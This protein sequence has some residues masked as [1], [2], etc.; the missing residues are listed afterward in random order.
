MSLLPANEPSPSQTISSLP[1]ADQLSATAQLQQ[2]LFE[3]PGVV[4][5]MAGYQLM[6][7]T[8]EGEL[9]L[10][11][12][13]HLAALIARMQELLGQPVSVV[14]V[15]GYRLSISKGP[16]RYLVTPFGN[17]PLFLPTT[18]ELE[19]EEDGYLGKRV[20]HTSPPTSLVDAGDVI[21][22]LSRPVAADEE[23]IE[24]G[25]DDIYEG[26]DDGPPA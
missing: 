2:L 14:P 5:P 8:E 3:S 23:E 13:P 9:K 12:F 20:V 25:G 1:H 21:D 16:A 24:L 18:P 15:L 17:F 26:D 4:P 19:L 7:F 11:E 10:E 22:A 6:L